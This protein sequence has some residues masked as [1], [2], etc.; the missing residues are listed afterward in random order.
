M[1]KFSEVRRGIQNDR[2]SEDWRKKD[3]DGVSSKFQYHSLTLTIFKMTQFKT[4]FGT[5][6]P[7]WLITG[8]PL[9]G[10]PSYKFGFRSSVQKNGPPGEGRHEGLVPRNDVLTDGFIRFSLARTLAWILFVPR[11]RPPE[12]QKALRTWRRLES[13]ASKTSVSPHSSPLGTFRA[14]RPQRRRARRNGCFR[15][16]HK[17]LTDFIKHCISFKMSRLT[18]RL[19]YRGCLKSKRCQYPQIWNLGNWQLC[20]GI[21]TYLQWT[22]IG[23][24]IGMD[25]CL[26]FTS[27]TICNT[28]LGSL[29]TPWSG[30]PV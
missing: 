23:P 9:S 6:D 8:L 20:W 4:S 16:L 19:S 25:C 27:W 17:G 28:V 22:I 10:L 26:E 14:E 30:Q 2:I 15:R 29:G 1:K 12:T 5:Q 18:K 3:H 13:L 7:F 11:R 24:A 21:N